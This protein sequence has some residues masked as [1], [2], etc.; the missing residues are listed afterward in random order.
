M[1]RPQAL[2]LPGFVT[3]RLILRPL[4]E[5]DA[6]ALFSIYGDAQVMR[7]ASD[8]VFTHLGMAFEL[9]ASVE[10]LLAEG[11][12]LEWGLEARDNGALI[13]TCGLHCFDATRGAAEIGVLLARS[14]WGQG[15]MTEAL[16]R[17]IDHAQ[18]E[19][20]LLL[21]RADIDVDNVRSLALFRRLGFHCVGGSW[22][23]RL[24]AP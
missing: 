1:T 3:T 23:E 10:R 13:G 15:Y 2:F 12:S 4:V 14:A 5:A 16:G 17:L 18:H 7:H 22:H 20:G 9:L 8:P 6:P 19:R 21:L 11:S 24:L